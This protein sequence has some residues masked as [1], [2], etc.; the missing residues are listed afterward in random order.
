MNVFLSYCHQD[1]AVAERLHCDLRK[2]G[3]SCWFDR[4][5]LLPGQRWRE[6]IETAIRK[7]S[8][9]IALLSTHSVTKEGFVQ[10]EFR[11]ALDVLSEMPPG[12]IYLIPA[13]IDSCTPAHQ[14]LKDLHWVDL[15][16][17]YESG[18]ER[19]LRAIRGDSASIPSQHSQ[20]NKPEVSIVG[21]Q[22]LSQPPEG[23]MPSRERPLTATPTLL[24]PE[25]T[26]GNPWWQ[27]P[28]TDLSNPSDER[29]GPDPSKSE[30]TKVRPWWVRPTTNSA[31]P[32]LETESTDSRQPEKAKANY[33][34]LRPG[35]DS[36]KDK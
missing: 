18:L 29:K 25:K 30:E 21:Q 7:S 5:D 23:Q 8:Y 35:D 12:R 1:L 15:F 33:W 31:K 36:N 13:R 27:R 14:V 19:I 10:R 11:W 4:E 17:I 32:A 9:F 26:K 2:H 20:A 3:I 16:P 24:Q 34:W 6:T 22:S 28:A